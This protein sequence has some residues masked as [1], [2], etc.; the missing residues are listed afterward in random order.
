VPH[1]S[2]QGHLGGFVGGVLVSS[3]IVWAPRSRR[4]LVQW[5]GMGLVAAAIAATVVARTLT[6]T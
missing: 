1:I 2:W 6:L 5:G 3:I 4:A